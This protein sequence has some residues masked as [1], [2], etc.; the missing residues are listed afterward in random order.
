M[1][2]IL[3]IGVIVFKSEKKKGFF[4]ADFWSTKKGKFSSLKDNSNKKKGFFRSV[5]IFLSLMCEAA[6][7][8]QN[9]AFGTQWAKAVTKVLK[10]D[11]H[12]SFN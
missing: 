7:M 10:M 8:I 9:M 2:C 6:L 12:K 3:R 1:S 4:L 5:A 11:L